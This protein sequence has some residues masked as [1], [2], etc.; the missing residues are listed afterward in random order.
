MEVLDFRLSNV[1]GSV[2]NS[3]SGL[4]TH[5]HLTCTWIR[6]TNESAIPQEDTKRPEEPVKRNLLNSWKPQAL[7]LAESA[8]TPYD[9]SIQPND[10]TRKAANAPVIQG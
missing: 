5:P 7:P 6:Q 9:C 3:N 8:I 2:G 4:V 10:L 1:I